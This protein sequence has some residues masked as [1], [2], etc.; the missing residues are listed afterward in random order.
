MWEG[1]IVSAQT[2]VKCV[3]HW[4]IAVADGPLSDGICKHCKITKAFRNSIFMEIRHITLE[5][6]HAPDAQNAK[7]W[8][9][10]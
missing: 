7:Q 1:F 8:P 6:D 4:M 9:H 3:H 10:Y 5:R 2:K